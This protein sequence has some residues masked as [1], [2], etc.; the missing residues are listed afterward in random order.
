MKDFNNELLYLLK[1]KTKC[2]WIKTYEEQKAINDIKNIVLEAFPGM[3][4][5][6]WTFFEGMQKQ[7]LT[8]HEKKA[9]PVKISPEQLLDNIQKNQTEGR[10]IKNTK[11]EVETIDKNENL[12]IIKDFHLI[13]DSKILIRGI[14]DVKERSADEMISYN[15][16]IVISPVVDIP[17]EHEKLFTIVDYALPSETQISAIINAF[18]KKLATKSEYTVP[19]KLTIDSCIKLANGLTLEEVKNYCARSIAQYNTLNETMF[20]QARLDLIKKTGILEYMEPHYEMGD[21][22]GN[23]SF[24]EWVSEV[25]ET[26]TPE[27]EA[28]G[29]EK[30]KGFLGLGVPGTAKTLSAEMIAS[31]L[32]LPLLKFNMSSVMHSHVGQS[33]KNMHNAISIVKSCSPCVLLIDEAE[34]TLSGTGSSN[35]TDGGTLM[36]V[37]GQLLE[38]LSSDDS[39]EVFTI[40]TS[41]DVTQL[42]PELTRSGRLDVLWYFG[43]PTEEERLEIFKIHF[44]KKPVK[45]ND[46][47][48]EYA[49]S[50]TEN[51][52]GA[53]IKECVKV[54]IRKA[55]YRYRIDGNSNITAE[56]VAIAKEEIIPVYDS[57]REKINALEIYAKTRARHANKVDEV[58]LDYDSSTNDG[59]LNMD[60]IN[61]M[62]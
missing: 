32:H 26:F 56:D 19:S 48:L 12:Y 50:I 4:L 38:F 29:V 31:E 55:F 2:I 22:G 16:I 45:V 36:R 42:P 8:K 43:L 15:P 54:A 21:M 18:A 27:A 17:L 3:N 5:Y 41:N 6:T 33:E 58:P 23:A 49:A 40:M 59:I 9:D 14:R 60:E 37:V 28:F 44:S 25:K 30:S 20:Y 11:G 7:P 10:K 13:N 39:K 53:E 1:A 51:F 46:N 34:K 24:K 35:K 61:G 47:V 52:T 57:S 62:I